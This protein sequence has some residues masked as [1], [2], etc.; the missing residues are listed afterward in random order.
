MSKSVGAA[1]PPWIPLFAATIFGAC[2]AFTS[3][4]TGVQSGVSG[5]Q[6]TASTGDQVKGLGTQAKDLVSKKKDGGDDGSGDDDDRLH[7]KEAQ[8][9]TPLDDKVDHKGKDKEDWRKFQLAGRPGVATFELFWDDDSANL[10]LDVF[11]AYGVNIGRSPPR[12]EGQ[13]V[14]RILVQIKKPGTVYVR[15]RAPTDKDK[16]IY[17][18]NVK[19]DGPPVAIA[20]APE[21]APNNPPPTGAPAPPPGPVSPL[22][23]PNKLQA[24]IISAYR[25]GTGW[26]FYIDKGSTQKIQQG[27]TGAILEGPEG[28]KF[29]DKGDFT[30]SQ[31]VDGGRSIARTTQSKSPGKNKRVLINLR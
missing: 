10:D 8:I 21:P 27:M 15:V 14:K 17:T 12:M 31:V 19:W 6:S 7:A 11:D 9:N 3:A 13:S 20:K 22:N 26:V 23:D 30:I 1:R 16:S 28:D 5:V 4:T 29:L 18:L 24:S 25:D 2:S